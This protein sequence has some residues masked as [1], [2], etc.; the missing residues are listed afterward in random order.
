MSLSSQ[1]HVC[2]DRL[3]KMAAA[4]HC[5]LECYSVTDGH[6]STGSAHNCCKRINSKLI[7]SAETSKNVCLRKLNCDV[8][9]SLSGVN[10]ALFA[11]IISKEF[12]LQESSDSLRALRQWIFSGLYEHEYL[13]NVFTFVSCGTFI[14]GPSCPRRAVLHTA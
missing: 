3:H 5:Q 14:F 8:S 4:H 10:T 7:V 6:C 9:Y 11:F 1:R 13:F 12:S 2:L